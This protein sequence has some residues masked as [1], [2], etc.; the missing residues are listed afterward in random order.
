MIATA[1]PNPSAEP[2]RVLLSVDTE[3]AGAIIHKAAVT[4]NGGPVR[5]NPPTGADASAAF[6]PEADQHRT[7]RYQFDGVCAAT[8]IPCCS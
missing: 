4:R 7:I 2:P 3:T 1:T 8:S 5:R 6:D